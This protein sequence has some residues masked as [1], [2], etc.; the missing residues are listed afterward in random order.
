MQDLATT[1]RMIESEIASNQVVLF[2]KGSKASPRC[3]FSAR[4]SSILE[5]L[6]VSYKD[7]DVLADPALRDEI[8]AFSQWPTIPQLYVGGRFI[9]GCDIVSDLY[10]SGE[11]HQLLGARQPESPS[12]TITERAA[13]EL[14]GL[15]LSERESLRLEIDPGNQFDL[16]VESS[17][18]DDV[19]LSDKGITLRLSPSSAKRAGGLLLDFVEDGVRAGFKIQRQSSVSA[20]SS[21]G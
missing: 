2:M 14:R 1:R 3:G 17:R 13:N 18:P 10:A 16:L 19:E 12:I 11:L 4:I 9:G 15:S 7:I 20:R 5:E 21:G 8:K 6:G